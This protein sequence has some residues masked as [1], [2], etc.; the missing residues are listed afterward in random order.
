M[1][2][3]WTLYNNTIGHSTITLQD[4]GTLY[5]NTVRKHLICWNGFLE[6]KEDHTQCFQAR[7]SGVSKFCG[8]SLET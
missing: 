8:G 6:W 3:D 7:Q 1:K 5:I 4:S 2:N